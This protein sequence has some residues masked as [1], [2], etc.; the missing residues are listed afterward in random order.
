MLKGRLEIF[1]QNT[2]PLIHYFESRSILVR[3]LAESSEASVFSVAQKYFRPL[4]C[5]GRDIICIMGC[6]S[7]GKSSLAK[8]LC[9]SIGGIHI[10][11]SDLIRDEVNRGCH[12]GSEIVKEMKIGNEIDTDVVLY[13]LQRSLERYQNFFDQPVILDGFPFTLEQFEVFER[14]IGHVKLIIQLKTTADVIYS[15]SI[16][17]EEKVARR[18]HLVYTNC[19]NSLEQA[20]TGDSRYY[21]ID[22]SMNMEKVAAIATL[23]SHKFVISCTPRIGDQAPNFVADTTNGTINFYFWKGGSWAVICSYS[24]SSNPVFMTELTSIAR[25]QKEWNDRSVKFLAL[26]HDT[27]DVQASLI[28]SMEEFKNSG[29][30][31]PIVADSDR[32][33]AI[34]YG[35]L[36]F[37]DQINFDDKDALVT[38]HSLIVIDP[39]NTIRAIITS[40]TSTTR[41]FDE[42]L[43]L[44]DSLQETQ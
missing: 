2:L 27:L 16:G 37:K 3:V 34:S 38:T 41:D 24:G 40:P 4:S 39:K 28:S 11:V 5:S 9:Q 22:A 43:N 14:T 1:H 36:E 8:K 15:R 6:H 23:L 42:I 7:S 30:A 17:E 31:F 32:R 12:L 33:V 25:R 20:L 26:T 10:C 29:T 35:I 21:V 13:L 44:L 19:V 18:K